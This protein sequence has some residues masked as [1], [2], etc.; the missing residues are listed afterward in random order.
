MIGLRTPLAGWADRLAAAE[1]HSGGTIRLAEETVVA[2][3][4]IRAVT[5]GA[6]SAAG[7][8]L[9]I[10]L[11]TEPNTVSQVGDTVALWLGPD[12]WLV[13]NGEQPYPHDDA[14]LG[15]SLVDIG[16]QRT[17]IVVCG[18]AAP[19]LLAHGCALDL[20]RFDAAW[21]AQTLLARARVVLWGVRRNEVRILVHASFARYVAE[22]LLDAATEWTTPQAG[23]PYQ[24][25]DE[26]RGTLFA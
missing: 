7:A 15:W 16:A 4:N 17:T 2:Q 24:R 1:V 9:G 3:A 18:P 6:R 8:A 22:W 26:S 23:A 11:P 19:D 12:E 5:A 14:L 13:I 21:C 20:E 25:L 10:T